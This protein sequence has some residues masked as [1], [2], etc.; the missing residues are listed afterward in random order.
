M[1]INPYYHSRRF[2]GEGRQ[3]MGWSKTS[4]FS[5]FGRYIFGTLGNEA[6]III[7]V[8]LSFL[9]PSFPRTPKHV[10]LNDPEWLF[11][12]NSALR[13]YV[14]SSEAWLSKLGYT[15]KLVSC[16]KCCRR[17]VNRKRTAAA[18]R[19][20]LASARLSCNHYENFTYS[21]WC[22]TT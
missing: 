1:T 15:L 22:M 3:T 12:I 19:S 10:T 14:W 17:S 4:I 9:S 6:N 21:H 18:S 16:S 13:W 8:L 5:A 2:P 7:I 11:C 20:F